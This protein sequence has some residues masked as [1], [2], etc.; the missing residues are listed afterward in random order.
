MRGR[1][2]AHGMK[3]STMVC[4]P[5]REETEQVGRDRRTGK[6]RGEE[7][8]EEKEGKTTGKEEKKRCRRRRRG[9]RQGRKRRRGEGG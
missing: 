8:Q 9:R 2:E 3:Q 6:G 5:R 1:K 7:V 4:L